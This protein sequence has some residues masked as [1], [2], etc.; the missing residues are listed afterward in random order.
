MFWRKVLSDGNKKA[1]IIYSRINLEEVA[2]A[3]KAI[4]NLT[5]KKEYST[6]I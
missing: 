4:P 3:R 6:N 5:T 1:G 2:I